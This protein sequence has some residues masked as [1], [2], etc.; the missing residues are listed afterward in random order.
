MSV[1]SDADKPQIE[2]DL[3]DEQV[4]QLLLEAESRIGIPESTQSER[5]ISQAVTN[6]PASQ[7]VPWYGQLSG[8]LVNVLNIQG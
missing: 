6:S 4:Q 1:S 3:T 8:A 2:A 7:P 5:P